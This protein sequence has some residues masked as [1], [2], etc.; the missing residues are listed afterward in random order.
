MIEVIGISKQYLSGR[1]HVQAL[2]GITFQV[3]KGTNLALVGKS[4]SGKTTLMNCI[5]GIETV[6]YTHLTLPTT[7]RV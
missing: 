4:G 5:G 1:G 3:E 6:S 7:E 2:S